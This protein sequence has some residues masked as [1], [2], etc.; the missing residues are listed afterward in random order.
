MVRFPPFGA[1]PYEVLRGGEVVLSALCGLAD[2]TPGYPDWQ[3]GPIQPPI[4]SEARLAELG[5]AITCAMAVM[6]A[7][8]ARMRGST[9]AGAIEVSQFEAATALMIF[10][11]GPCG[12]RR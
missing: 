5:A 7:L 4:Q 10:D 6:A 11:W 1:G 9:S 8:V 3:E 2:C 12:L